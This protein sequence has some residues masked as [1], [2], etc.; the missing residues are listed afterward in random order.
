MTIR[1]FY[2]NK[3]KWQITNVHIISSVTHKGNQ[4]IMHCI[5]FHIV[6][7]SLC[8]NGYNTNI[9]NQNPCGEYER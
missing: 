9:S 7:A 5:P 3:K 2:S 4:P 8:F 1:R 6:V